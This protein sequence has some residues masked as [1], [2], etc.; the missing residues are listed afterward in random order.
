[1]SKRTILTI[2]SAA[3]LLAGCAATPAATPEQT[4]TTTPASAPTSRAPTPE[5]IDTWAAP[6]DGRVLDGDEIETSLPGYWV[7][8]WGEILF[9][10]DDDGTVVGAYNYDEGIVI[11]RIEGT[12]MSGWWCEVPSREP[13][14]DAGT[15][16]MRLVEGSAGTSIDGRW[17]YGVAGAEAWNDNWDI[18]S[19]STE[20]PLPELVARLDTA[21]DL[22]I[23][24]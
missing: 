4:E 9:R 13:D 23:P 7:G 24:G 3:L 11:G 14:I 15:V 10:I 1:M 20:T 8:D 5:P 16:E 19:I 18:D 22:C 17:T 2:A 12:V 21:R 6:E